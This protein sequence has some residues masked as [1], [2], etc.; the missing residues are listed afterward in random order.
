MWK[1]FENDKYY[2]CINHFIYYP[3]AKQFRIFSGQKLLTSIKHGEVILQETIER[4][5]VFH[6]LVHQ[7]S[8]MSKQAFQVAVKQRDFL[9]ETKAELALWQTNF[10]KGLAVPLCLLDP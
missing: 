2:T 7:G 9:E 8:Q 10:H 3:Y 5:G 6:T 1:N 4:V